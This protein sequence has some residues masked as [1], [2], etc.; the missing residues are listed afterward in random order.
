MFLST[1]IVCTVNATSLPLGESAGSLMRDSP[2]SIWTSNVRFCA[3]RALEVSKIKANRMDFHFSS[4]GAG[5]RPAA[6]GEAALR[7]PPCPPPQSS[8]EPVGGAN[9][10]LQRRLQASVL[11]RPVQMKSFLTNLLAGP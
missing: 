11:Q 5:P 7:D 8:E 9:F 1:S 2:S 4:C 3:N 10:S 6:G